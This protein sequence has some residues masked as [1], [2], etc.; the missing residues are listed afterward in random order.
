LALFPL[1][2]DPGETGN[3]LKKEKAVSTTITIKRSALAL[4]LAGSIASVTGAQILT[5]TTKQQPAAYC[6][7]GLF[8]LTAGVARFHV[9]LD[10][11]KSGPPGLVRMRLID[12]GG[13]VVKTDDVW[14]GPGQ[15]ATLELSGSGLYRA[16]AEWFESVTDLSG[17]RKVVGT[18]ELFDIGQFRAV[19]PVICSP[20]DDGRT[21]PTT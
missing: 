13:T 8:T 6:T 3:S 19:V 14:L 20:P 7:G 12:Y 17:R 5:T 1:A 4:F 2:P 16:Q 18:A 15:S 9:S 21:I 10:D 11:L